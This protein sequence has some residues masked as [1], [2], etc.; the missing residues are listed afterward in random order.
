MK[1]EEK[2]VKEKRSSRRDIWIYVDESVL[3]VLVVLVN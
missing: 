1:K 3:V 2:T